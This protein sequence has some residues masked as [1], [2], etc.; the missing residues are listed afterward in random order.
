MVTFD[1]EKMLRSR[2]HEI[3]FMLMIAGVALVADICGVHD[4]VSILVGGLVG[5][6]LSRLLAISREIRRS[7]ERITFVETRMYLDGLFKRDVQ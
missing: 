3:L 4:V 2:R 6:L 7:R 1:P 5:L